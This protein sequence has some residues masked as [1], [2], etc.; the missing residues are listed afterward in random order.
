MLLAFSNNGINLLLL[1]LIDQKRNIF[2]DL[3]LE[4]FV[5]LSIID[6]RRYDLVSSVK[7]CF[8]DA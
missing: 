3:S 1:G 4:G 8:D 2:I 7:I 6:L 5:Q